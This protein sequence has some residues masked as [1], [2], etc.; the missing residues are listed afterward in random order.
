MQIWD[1]FKKIFFFQFLHT[2]TVPLEPSLKNLLTTTVPGEDRLLK[3]L[4]FFKLKIETTYNN[5]Y[6]NRREKTIF[7]TTILQP[8]WKPSLFND[9]RN[10]DGSGT[11][12]KYWF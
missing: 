2:T 10:N 8:S 11:V 1:F 4:N 7:L 9:A 5:D 3:S 6:I 12:I